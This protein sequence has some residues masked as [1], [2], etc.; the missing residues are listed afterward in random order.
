MRIVALEPYDTGSHR[1]WLRGYARSSRHE[2]VPLTM[3]G[4]Y[5]KWRMHGGAVSLAREMPRLAGCGS[6][7]WW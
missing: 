6:P 5:W 1:D 2:V 3:S 4:Q 7:T